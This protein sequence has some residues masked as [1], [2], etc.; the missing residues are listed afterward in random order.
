MAESTASMLTLSWESEVDA[1]PLEFESD[2]ANLVSSPGRF[3]LERHL[4]VPLEGIEVKRRALDATML[5]VVGIDDH[6]REIARAVI[7]D[8]RIHYHATPATVKST[9]VLPHLDSSKIV[10]LQILKPTN[11]KAEVEFHLLATLAFSCSACC[12]GQ[13]RWK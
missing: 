10:A 2:L 7:S 1:L 6:G 5:V 13:I 11:I 9:F 3:S 8:P 12:P 4:A